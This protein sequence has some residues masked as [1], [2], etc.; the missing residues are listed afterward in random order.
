VVVVFF[1]ERKMSHISFTRKKMLLLVIPL[2]LLLAFFLVACGGGN[3]A[4]SS[5]STTTSTSSSTTSQN[6]LPGNDATAVQSG[7]QQAQNLLQSLDKAQ[8][9]ADNA[10]NTG[11]Q[12]D[13]NQAP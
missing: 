10:T 11:D 3:S 5:S 7:D 6:G 12:Q 1:K 2:L 13:T 8:Q 9:D 4:T